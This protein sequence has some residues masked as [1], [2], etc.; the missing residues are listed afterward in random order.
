M[1]CIPKEGGLGVIDLKKHNE[2]LL[3]NLDKF[4]NHKDI[5]WVSL[6]WEKHYTNGKLPSHTK[7]GSFW[8]RDILKLIDCFKAFTSIQIQNGESCLF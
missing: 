5:P 3:K 2:A 6:I 4:F 8:W 7:K 1:V